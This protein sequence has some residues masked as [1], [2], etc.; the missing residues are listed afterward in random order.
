MSPQVILFILVALFVV[1]WFALGTQW[2]VRKGDAALRWLQQGLPQ[3][4]EKTTLRW[5]GSSAVELKIEQGKPPFRAA[6]VVLA[7]EPRDVPPLW[8]LA[9]LRG[10]HDLFIFRGTLSSRPSL[11]MEALNPHSWSTRGLD[12]KCEARGWSAL[13]APA[14]LV[15][16]AR[17][18]VQNASELLSAAA[19]SG[20]P[21]VRLSLRR[22]APEFEVQW[23]LS[24]L[25]AHPSPE[26]FQTIRR[27]T[28][29]L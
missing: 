24:H 26:I 15:V 17:N 19:L 28:D 1:G 9:R 23:Q 10:R 8:L 2:N 20:C 18:H 5:L 27:I 6:E 7:L 22:D 11:E 3:V 13:P 12:R 16:Y 25:L 14:P 4:G 21:L 29:C